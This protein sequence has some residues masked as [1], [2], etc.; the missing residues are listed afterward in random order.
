MDTANQITH[1]LL[2]TGQ[3]H[4]HAFIATDGIDPEW[5]FRYANYLQTKLNS[6]LGTDLAQSHIVYELI[7][8]EKEMA[9]NNPR[10]HWTQYYATALVKTYA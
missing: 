2:Q 8:L 4:H 6:I 9:S 7:R 1:L 3:A 10:D 5:A